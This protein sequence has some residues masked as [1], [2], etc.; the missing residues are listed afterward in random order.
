MYYYSFHTYRHSEKLL[1][2]NYCTHNGILYLYCALQW[3]R[4]K[5]TFNPV[6]GTED[7][8]LNK[9]K[10][11]G[12]ERNCFDKPHLYSLYHAIMS[13]MKAIYRVGVKMST[14]S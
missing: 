9:N 8:A 7:V 13:F 5:Q 1:E 14:H 2:G 4:Y 10:L 12:F 11:F 6:L 3:T